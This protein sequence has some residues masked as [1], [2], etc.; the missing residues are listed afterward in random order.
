M[1]H[2]FDKLQ[3]VTELVSENNPPF[4]FYKMRVNFGKPAARYRLFLCSHPLHISCGKSP[5]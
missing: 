4:L 2:L 1:K 3:K 5:L